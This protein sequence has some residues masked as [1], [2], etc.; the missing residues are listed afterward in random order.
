LNQQNQIAQSNGVYP[1]VRLLRSDKEHIVLSVIRSLRYLCVGVGNVPHTK[2][3]NTISTSRGVKLLIALM[4]HSLAELIQV[5]AAYTL[6]CVSLG[7]L[8][9]FF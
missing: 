6:G 2:N 7:E 4:V 9:N 5:E 1:L 3:Q 8:N